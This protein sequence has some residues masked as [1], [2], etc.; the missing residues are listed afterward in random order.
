MGSRL[1]IEQNRWGFHYRFSASAYLLAESVTRQGQHLRM[2]P[3]G[4]RRFITAIALRQR[5][6]VDHLCFLVSVRWKQ[7]C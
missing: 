1:W 2:S 7:L 3:A 5:S 4:R 6:L